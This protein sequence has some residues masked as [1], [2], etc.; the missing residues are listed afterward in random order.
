MLSDIYKKRNISL[1]IKSFFRLSE[2]K[3]GNTCESSLI[4]VC[5]I[6]QY[7]RVAYSVCIG[8]PV[9]GWGVCM[10]A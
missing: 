6:P 2:Y 9:G 3:I 4:T 8:I 10:V 5:K 1:E 7:I